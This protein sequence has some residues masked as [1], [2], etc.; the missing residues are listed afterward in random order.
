MTNTFD[1][2]QHGVVK[3]PMEMLF[4]VPTNIKIRGYYFKVR[5][6]MPNFTKLKFVFSVHGTSCH[7]K[8]VML[9][10]MRASRPAFL[11]LCTIIVCDFFVVIWR[12]S[13][14]SRTI[15]SIYL[16]CFCFS[17][18]FANSL[19]IADFFAWKKLH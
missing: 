1:L 17:D 5:H 19:R 4:E 14:Y 10:Q 7:L 13:A 8:S 9:P 18:K 15:R 6:K 3:F 16:L 2:I 11:V 12:V